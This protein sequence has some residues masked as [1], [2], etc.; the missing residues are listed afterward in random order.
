MF[1]RFIGLKIWLSWPSQNLPS[2][3]HTCLADRC[4][5]DCQMWFWVFIFMCCLAIF[6]L[7]YRFW[8]IEDIAWQGVVLEQTGPAG[9]PLCGRGDPTWRLKTSFNRRTS[10]STPWPRHTPWR[11]CRYCRKL[12]NNWL[13]AEILLGLWYQRIW[14]GEMDEACGTN[15]ETKIYV[16]TRSSSK[17][18]PDSFY[19]RE[20]KCFFRGPEILMGTNNYTWSL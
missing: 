2:V 14:I 19:Y 7:L 4:E 10:V 18:K 17:W 13:T 6:G 9:M 1:F 16:Y 11:N 3:Q 8:W 5:N 12:R 15:E 20:S